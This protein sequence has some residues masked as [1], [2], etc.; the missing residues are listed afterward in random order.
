MIEVYPKIFLMK[1]L[2]NNYYVDGKIKILI[3][4]GF[5][6]KEKVDIL[7]LTHIHPD[8]VFFAKKIQERTNCKIFIGQ[9]DENIDEFLFYCPSWK[10]KEIEKFK[11]DRVLKK[12]DKINIGQYDF[13]VLQLP[14]HT[15]GSI[16]LY[17]KKHEILFSGD[18]IFENGLIG[19]TDFI[20]SSEELMQK[21][22]KK[23]KKLKIKHLFSG[24]GIIK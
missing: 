7:I 20:H 5:D 15:L 2:C 16:G 9:D 4:A 21:T 13:Q 6:F 17:E 12:N 10:G 8:H 1:G 3:D 24:H 23:L 11:I 18:T 19:R 14:G 22:L